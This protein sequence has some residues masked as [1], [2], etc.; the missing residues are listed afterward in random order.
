MADLPEQYIG[1][2]G[3]SKERAHLAPIMP[4]GSPSVTPAW[5]SRVGGVIRIPGRIE[6]RPVPAM[7]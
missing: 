2:T 7:G 4:G 1:P 6:L 3:D 5:S